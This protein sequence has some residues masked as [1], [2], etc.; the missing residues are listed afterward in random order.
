MKKTFLLILLPL[1]SLPL[2]A[3]NTDLRGLKTVVSLL[4]GP[5]AVVGK[6]YAVLI[7]ID[8]YQSWT[9]LQNPVKDAKEIKDILSRRY[10]F[11]NFLELYDEAAT[12]AGIIKLFD[13][14]IN[15]TRSEDSILIFYAGHGHLDKT[16]NSGF[17]IPVDGG[18]DVYEQANWLPNSQIRG[19]I[20]NMKARH[21]ALIADSCFSGDF[22]NPARGMAPTITNEYF[23]NAY[24][25]ISRQV[26]TSGA[27][28]SV[29]DESQ[30]TRQ[31]KLA[32]EGNIA[33]YLD[34]LMLYNEIRLSVKQTTPLFGDLKDSGHED[35]SSFLLFLR[36]GQQ[37][38]QKDASNEEEPSTRVKISKVYGTA[39]VET[40][41]TGTLFID[42]V[43]QGQVPVG[44]LATIENL[45][46]GPH[47]IVMLYDDGEKATQTITVKRGQTSAVEFSRPVKAESKVPPAGG[48]QAPS[49][50]PARDVPPSLP[51][52]DGGPLP[53]ASIKIDG[54]LDDW[55]NIPPVVV[56]SQDATETWTITKVYLAKD[57]ENFYIRLDIADKTP[58]SFFHP[59]NFN[60][61][62][63]YAIYIDNGDTRNNVC[64]RAVFVDSHG[65]GVG[66]YLE[67]G[68]REKGTWRHNE[69]HY[70]NSLPVVGQFFMKGSSME[71]AVELSKIKGLLND[72]LGPT[73]RYRIFGWTAIGWDDFSDPRQTEAGYFSFA[74]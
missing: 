37:S 3:Q 19:F 21:V 31:L 69:G 46:A 6:Q 57:K 5:T 48:N 71:I 49:A 41:T 1:V 12:K 22:L 58:S 9:A 2:F 15:D 68:V 44:S 72:H 62:R 64:V 32:L 67:L 38:P 39:T 53:N 14:L 61:S 43:S 10:Y 42:G 23:K 16:S 56:S 30:F 11:S 63:F 60:N 55:Q 4:E 24:A 47:E 36:P 74:E 27:S 20:S 65:Y 29:P 73:K 59:F 17:W 52:L 35:G 50:A 66:W 70:A 51:L 25:R 40:D 34:P 28:E 45:P 26:L 13:K 7:A 18:M 8:K 33:P 54:N